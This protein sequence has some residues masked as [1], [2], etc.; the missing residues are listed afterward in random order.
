MGSSGAGKS[1]LLNVLSGRIQP[2]ELKG[3][4]LING[5][6]REPGSFK[7]IVGYIEQEDIMFENLSVKE[8]L[9]YSALLRL[10][11]TLETEEK[12]QRVND[13]VDE[14]GL[15]KCQNTY[16]GGGEKRGVSGGERKRVSIGVELVTSPSVLFLDEPTSGLDAFTAQAIIEKITELAKTSKKTVLMTI[17]QP[18][19]DILNLFDKV[20][21]LSGGKT[22]FF[23]SVADAITHFTEL[24][25]PCPGRVN[26]SD[27]F[28]DTLTVDFRSE[29]AKVS[30]NERIQKFQDT[31]SKI[32]LSKEYFKEVVEIHEKHRARTQRHK[33]LEAAGKSVSD[34]TIPP[35]RNWPNLWVVEFMT[36]LERNIKDVMRNPATLGATL[37]QNAFMMLLIG[38]IYFQIDTSFSGI[39]GRVGLF[40]FVITNIMFGTVMPTI[41]V[42]PL[43]RRIIKHERASGSY[44]SSAAFMAKFV[45]TLPLLIA[46]TLLFAVP[47]YWIIGLQ[48]GADKYFT[49]I[50]ILVSYAFVAQSLGLALGAAVPNVT[51]GQIIGPLVIVFFLLFSGQLVNVETMW[52]GLK[53]LK[54][55]SPLFYSYGAL[56]QNEFRGLT[57][58]CATNAPGCTQSG[59]TVIASFG[60]DAIGVWE[61]IAVLWA[62][63]FAY[64]GLGYIA[65]RIQSKPLMKLK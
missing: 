63:V 18:R 11:G 29:D 3:N 44:R 25:Y 23:G 17:H 45:S 9:T 65:F 24:G 31:W 4:I 56:C 58:S 14:L 41:G 26:P 16:I 15:A 35:K 22:V 43:Q 39:Q 34:A 50:A 2:G 57:F 8:T 32:Q 38:F 21:L 33:S 10:P 51:V 48:S 64:T 53:W 36:L 62:F 55:I 19:T 1:T 37:G 6:T 5:E 20:I 60:F 46:G 13:V 52:A 42:F 12:S 40:F 54:W 28:L 47:V 30:S 59:E 27:F 49:F 7:Q 61:S